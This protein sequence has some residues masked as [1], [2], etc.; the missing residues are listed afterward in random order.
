[1]CIYYEISTFLFSTQVMIELSKKAIFGEKVAKIDFAIIHFLTCKSFLPLRLKSIRNGEIGQD[2]C[3]FKAILCHSFIERSY[4]C[5]IRGN[6]QSL[7]CK[8]E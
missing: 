8:N 1:M 4:F 5:V 6:N 2:C 3:V 7:Q